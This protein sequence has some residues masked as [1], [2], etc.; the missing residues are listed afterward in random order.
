[1]VASFERL[2]LFVTNYKMKNIILTN[3]INTEVKE[4]YLH[5]LWNQCPT[6]IDEEF[7]TRF[8]PE[9]ECKIIHSYKFKDSVIE[10]GLH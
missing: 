3:V 7:A 5:L 10:L 6:E 9:Y 2:F 1:V 4:G 8:Y